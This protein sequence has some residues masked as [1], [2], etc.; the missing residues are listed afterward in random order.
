MLNKT[1][2][3]MPEFNP[4]EAQKAANDFELAKQ[5]INNYA[6]IPVDRERLA[7]NAENLELHAGRWKAIEDLSTGKE[8]TINDPENPAGSETFTIGDLKIRHYDKI[9][10]ITRGIHGQFIAAPFV[11]IIKDISSKSKTIRDKLKIEAVKNSLFEKY[12]APKIEIITKQELLKTGFNNLFELNPDQQLELQN[13]INTRVQ[14]ESPEEILNI[15]EKVKTP[16]E[17]VCQLLFNYTAAQDRIKRKFDTGVEFAIANGE[18]YY[19]PYIL[20]GYPKLDP[21]IPNGVAYEGSQNVDMVEDGTWA[22]Y[23]QYLSI[24][25]VISK[26]GLDFLKGDIT[27]IDKYYNVDSYQG[28]TGMN[29]QNRVENQMVEIIGTNQELRNTNFLTRDG[30]DLQRALYARIGSKTSSFRIQQKYVTHRWTARMKAV[31]RLYNG[32]P[33]E[34]IVAGHYAFNPKTDLKIRNIIAPQVWEGER[35][36]GDWFKKVQAMPY[37]YDNIQN[38]WNPKLGI[39]GGMYNTLMGTTKNYSLISNGKIWNYRINQIMARMDEIESTN[40]GKIALF[41]LN[42]KPKGIKWDDWLN[43]LLTTKI[44]IVSHNKEFNLSPQEKEVINSIDLGRFAEAAA[45]IQKLQH[46]EGE[47]N[48]A[49]FYSEAK[50]GDIGQYS[51]NQNAALQIEASDRQMMP[52]IEKHRI[53][54]SNACNALLK[55]SL[56]AYRDNEHVKETVLDDFLK[57]HYELNIKDEDI[58]QYALTTLDTMNEMAAVKKMTD[59]AL[60]F[61]QNGTISLRE[62][63]RLFSAQT[64]AEAQDIIDEAET[65]R[66]KREASNAQQQKE[67]EMQ[68]AKIQQDLIKLKQDFDATQKAL[69]RRLKIELA[70]INSMLMANAN[71]IDG[72]KVNDSLKKAREE[73]IAKQK[74]LQEE[75]SSIE[76]IKDKEFSTNIQIANIKA[77]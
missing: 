9:G 6:D 3:R 34:F 13:Q 19:R 24:E 39:I 1:T 43:G 62:L 68:N 26:I 12:M 2:Y 76:R 29:F 52:F 54:V 46:A 15:L 36:G 70:D 63:S 72:D 32:K 7:T 49:M 25:D 57:T 60:V 69:D 51:T 22:S 10:R 66:E 5:I 58:G 75:L 40:H 14:K 30:Q 8:I 18:E 17:Q 37:Q 67:M 41:T 33:K 31:T 42:A 61:V 38:P 28:Y 11:Y 71:D 48:K 77:G 21:L 65:K 45:E 50:G 74:M 4:T 53:I 20:N 59:L 73:M 55:C 27:N 56:I 23:T 47:L 16:D 35:Y 64:M 44:G